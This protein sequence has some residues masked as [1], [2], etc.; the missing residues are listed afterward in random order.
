MVLGRVTVALLAAAVLAS[1]GCGSSSGGAASQQQKIQQVKD[2]IERIASYIAHHQ[3]FGYRGPLSGR[4]HAKERDGA[5]AGKHPHKRDGAR[6]QRLDR[7][8]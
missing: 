7:L 8:Q 4:N 1:S 5:K 2:G 3:A 6:D